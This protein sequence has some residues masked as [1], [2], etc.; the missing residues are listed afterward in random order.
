MQY[1]KFIK[2]K[3]NLN[4]KSNYD[5]IFNWSIKHKGNFWDSIWD[6]CKVKGLKGKNKIKNSKIF[7]KNLFLTD[8]KLNFA[9]NILVKSDNSK[10]ITFISENGFKE[11]ISWK[12]LYNSS[13]KIINFLIK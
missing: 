6:F 7:Y 12:N 9:E 13:S 1:E 8:Y 2:D 5:K 3:Y 10:A 11:K 4:F